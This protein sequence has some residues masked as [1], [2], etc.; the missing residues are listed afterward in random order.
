MNNNKFLVVIFL[1]V[2]M[3]AGFFALQNVVSANTAQI[4]RDQQR[5]E[6]LMAIKAMLGKY[7]DQFQVYPEKL[8]L[9]TDT[10]AIPAS[11]NYKGDLVR[12]NGVA[13]ADDNT[14]ID[15]TSYCYS[16]NG[17][18]LGV[19]LESGY[20]FNQGEQDCLSQD[21]LPLDYLIAVR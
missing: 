17:Y 4:L 13:I 10:I 5:R 16:S 11:A 9:L 1:L 21:F 8:V 14:S 12:L 20:I 18:K 6:T 7:Y 3:I 19:V 15:R 2:V